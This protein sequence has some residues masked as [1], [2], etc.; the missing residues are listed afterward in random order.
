ML[1]KIRKIITSK[2]FLYGLF[3]LI[4]I[5]LYLFNLKYKVVNANVDIYKYYICYG[6][7]AIIILAVIGVLIWRVNFTSKIDYVKLFIFSASLLGGIYLFSAPLFTGSDEQSH[8]YRIYE[9]VDG[10][11]ITPV[12]GDKIGSYL[13]SSLSKIYTI[14]SNVS[15]NYNQHIKYS[16]LDEMIKTPLVPTEKELY[17]GSSGK[18][19]VAASLYSPLQYVPHIIGFFI[20][21]ILNLNPYFIGILGRICN[22]L[23]YIVI[24]SYGIKKIPQGKLFS[25]AILLSPTLL[26]GATTLSSDGFTNA[27]I[28]LFISY[29]ISFYESKNE[30]PII[31]KLIMLILSIFISVCKLVYLPIIFLVFLIPK[32]CFKNKKDK[33]IYSFVSIIIACVC[34][35]VWMNIT[36]NYLK[37]YYTNSSLQKDF[38]FSNII[39]YLFIVIRTYCTKFTELIENMLV[40]T[41]LY[42]SQLPVYSIISLLYLIITF[43]T[44]FN[45]NRKKYINKT[46][47]IIIIFVILLLGGL[48]ASALY[49]QCTAQ[50][51]QIANP[52]VGGLQGRYFIP[53]L[54][55]L[56]LLFNFKKSIIN[57]QKLFDYL[58][59]IQYPVILTIFVQFII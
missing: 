31:D 42:H 21:K 46:F 45:D 53:L 12:N 16:D 33:Y 6:I 3:F 9:I 24:C 7:Y 52:T 22:L 56:M 27:L 32:D 23:F 5:I 55:V 4:S 18:D 44:I 54:F 29:L 13:P 10:N 57:E 19:Y 36:S 41:E 1:N 43:L 26:V 40:G 38:I 28:F 37:V 25:C 59:L 8:Y 35:A 49:V 14:R 20:G 51:I 39:E 50:F 48:I 11:F 15:Y 34:S 2:Y 47:K 30:I 17:S 58:L